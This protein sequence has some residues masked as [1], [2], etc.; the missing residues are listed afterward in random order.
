MQWITI[1]H[2]V[3][4][5]HVQLREHDVI[6][7]DDK[8]SARDV[9]AMST[10]KDR[11][12]VEGYSVDL[13]LLTVEVYFNGR[14]CGTVGYDGTVRATSDSS[15]AEYAA[16]M[17]RLGLVAIAAKGRRFHQLDSMGTDYA[18]AHGVAF[19]INRLF[20]AHYAIRNGE[21]GVLTD[22]SVE[23]VEYTW[24]LENEAI[25]SGP[26]RIF[27]CDMCKDKVSR[28]GEIAPVNCGVL[29]CTG[30][31]REVLPTKG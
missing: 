29:N 2:Q 30:L 27:I 23:I 15:N 25:Q 7:L 21:V 14:W 19:R 16:R 6:M 10:V 3:Q 28:K 1:L 13:D 18:H 31:Y 5:V 24:R 20:S 11:V 12:V 17:G 8:R 9:A 26:P 22:A 4:V